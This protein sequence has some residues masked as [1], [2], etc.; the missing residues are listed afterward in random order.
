MSNI[1]IELY[2]ARMAEMD[3]ENWKE[4]RKNGLKAIDKLR[5]FYLSQYLAQKEVM[6]NG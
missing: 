5:I 1:E 6:A 3:W 2:L 4:S